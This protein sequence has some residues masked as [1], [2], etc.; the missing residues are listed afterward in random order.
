MSIPVMA[1]EKI[2]TPF[3]LIQSMKACIGNCFPGANAVS[4]AFYDVPNK[5]EKA[6]FVSV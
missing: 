5:I 4:H 6:S 1:T 2:C 3:P